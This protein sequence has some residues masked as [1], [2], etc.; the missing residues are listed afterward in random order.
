[1]STIEGARPAADLYGLLGEL[2][3][4]PGPGLASAVRDG[5]V[6]AAIE[7]MLSHAEGG[8]IVT[9]LDAMGPGDIEEKDLEAEYIRLFDAP[10]NKPTPLYTGVYAQRRRDAMEEL[11]RTYRHFGLTVDSKSHDL[12][13]YVPT[14]LEF[15]RFLTLGQDAGDESAVPAFQAAKADILQRHLLPWVTETSTRLGER[16]AHTFYPG[17]LALLR[18]FAAQELAALGRGVAIAR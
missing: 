6:R 12:P 2:L 8:E 5:S 9:P 15:L 7:H 11:L 13:D 3:S 1:M 14:V 18:E 17:V 16:S 10:E 4:F